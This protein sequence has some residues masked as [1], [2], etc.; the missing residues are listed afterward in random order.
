[1]QL[2]DI[3]AEMP[4]MPEILVKLFQEL[5]EN[6]DALSLMQSVCIIP[7]VRDLQYDARRARLAPDSIVQGLLYDFIDD[8]ATR[9]LFVETLLK[10]YV[11]PSAEP[12]I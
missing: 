7:D 11:P 2:D 5:Q 6:P 12:E 4:D 1:M 10:D 3:L 8:V 9:D